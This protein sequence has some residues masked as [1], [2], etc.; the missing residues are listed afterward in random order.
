MPTGLVS[1]NDTADVILTLYMHTLLLCSGETQVP[2]SMAGCYAAIWPPTVLPQ[3]EDTG[4]QQPHP[5]GNI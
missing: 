5:R 3:P 4:T 1:R 2:P